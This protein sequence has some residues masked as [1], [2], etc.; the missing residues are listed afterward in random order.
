MLEALHLNA[1]YPDKLVLEAFNYTF[2]PG[3]LYILMGK[4]GSGKTTLL[5]TLGGWLK[6]LAGEVLINQTSIPSLPSKERALLTGRMAEDLHDLSMPLKH[7]VEMGAYPRSAWNGKL[8]NQEEARVKE[9]LE[10]LEILDL[11]SQPMNRLSSGQR[12]KASI[13]QLL[14][15]NPQVLLL[16]EPGSSLDPAARFELMDRLKGLTDPNRIVILVLHDLDLA[17][18]YGD[19]LLIL[20][21]KHCIFSGTAQECVDQKRLQEAFG[22]EMKD[23]DPQ[24]RTGRLFP[25]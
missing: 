5:H 19:V 15:Q 2:E 20:K 1:G 10:Q 3:K 21:E 22:L 18:R 23:W 14:V 16:D 7:F 6:P 12:Q 11:A 9:V 25:V 17:L 13:A 24:T 4:N 8:S